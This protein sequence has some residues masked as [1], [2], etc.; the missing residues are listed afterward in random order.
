VES[1]VFRPDHIGGSETT[2]HTPRR[3]RIH[4]P[5][6][7]GRAR[8]RRMAGRNGGAIAR[9]GTRRACDVRSHRCHE[10]IESSR[11]ALVQLVRESPAAGS[12][13]RARSRFGWGLGKG[14]AVQAAELDAATRSNNRDFSRSFLRHFE[15][16]HMS[17]SVDREIRQRHRTGSSVRRPSGTRMA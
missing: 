5:T 7:Q 13:H 4:H 10:G 6:A 11:R 9:C 14:G 12:E 17:D 16:Q 3:R 15:R 8:R 1:T 2:G